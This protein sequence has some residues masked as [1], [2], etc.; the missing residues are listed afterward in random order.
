[1]TESGL[2][3]HPLSI[4]LSARRTERKYSPVTG[5][6]RQS[7]SIME[8]RLVSTR[9]DNCLSGNSGELSIWLLQQFNPIVPEFS[10]RHS[11]MVAVKPLLDLETA[12]LR[13][14]ETFIDARQAPTLCRFPQ[15]SAMSLRR[16]S[17]VS[18]GASSQPL[19][20]AFTLHPVISVIS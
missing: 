2:F 14:A 11:G 10:L 8:D 18:Y 5:S 3:K 9:C 4:N 17:A 7:N 12:S 19:L 1:M 16:V 20:L 6:E 13:T 15:S